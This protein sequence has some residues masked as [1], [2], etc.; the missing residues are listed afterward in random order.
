MVSIGSQG[1]ND[2][3]SDWA[4]SEMPDQPIWIGGKRRTAEEK[5]YNL[6]LGITDGGDWSW[7]DGTFWSSSSYTNWGTGYPNNY[8]GTQDCV[9]MGGPNAA[10]GYWDDGNCEE[11]LGFFCSASPGNAK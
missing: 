1:L 10:G 4:E 7:A 2:F 5:W 11:E 9:Y 6:M 3:L 8:Q